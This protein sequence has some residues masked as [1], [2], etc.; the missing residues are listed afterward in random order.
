MTRAINA[1]GLE[2]IQHFEGLSLRVYL[3]VG[4]KPTIG[5]G[6]LIREGED[7]TAGISS[8]YAEELLKKDLHYAETAVS[9]LVRTLLTENQFSALVSLVFNT[10]NAP[11]LGPLGRAL[12]QVYEP[13]YGLAANEFLHWNHVKG[14]VVFG[15]TRRREAE[16]ALFL[17]P[18]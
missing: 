17:T 10:G 6:H 7:F 11:L 8:E 3:D 18:C 4:K 1:K 9:R 5:Y 15:L 14:K 16:R 12:N 13:D 2:L